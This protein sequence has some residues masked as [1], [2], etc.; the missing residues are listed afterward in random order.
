MS[1]HSKPSHASPR[2]D[3][4]PGVS[5]RFGT[6]S[7]WSVAGRSAEQLSETPSALWITHFRPRLELG[8][9]LG[10]A[11]AVGGATSAQAA[12]EATADLQKSVDAVKG[13]VKTLQTDVK[14]LQGDVKKL[15]G[16]KISGFVQAQVETNDASKEGV[17]NTDLSP[18]N[19]FQFSVRRGRLKAAYT[20]VQNTEVSLEID[21]TGKGVSVKEAQ[22]TWRLPI[23]ALNVSLTA[24]QF[25]VPFGFE[26]PY[27]SSARELPEVSSI[28]SN[29]FPGEYDRGVKLAVN[30]QFLNLQVG[31]FNGNGTEDTGT[32]VYYKKPTDENADGVVDPSELDAVEATNTRGALNFSNND[33]DSFKDIVGRVG[34]DYKLGDKGAVAAGASGYFGSWATFD[35]AYLDYEGNLQNTNAF[36]QHVKNRVGVDLEARYKLV[37][38]LGTTEVRGEYITG[39]GLYVKNT[40]KQVPV[41]GYSATLLQGLT[42]NAQLAFRVDFFDKNADPESTEDEVTAIEPALLLFPTEALRLTA[43]YQIVNDFDDKD[44][45]GNKIDKANNRLLLRLQG[46]F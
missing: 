39:T 2:G 25:K 43:S 22:A 14:S 46:K 42:S 1:V 34:I 35:Q 5:R 10:L 27:S 38:S 33:R 20:G 19:L 7:L 26:I 37:E 23:D 36:T 29:L 21:A 45:A 18:A 30:W 12:E 32:F 24:G 3:S 44:D 4:R 17:K 8:L 41:A 6:Q 11:L 28:L 40:E 9:G 31:L 16:L 13:D 15:K